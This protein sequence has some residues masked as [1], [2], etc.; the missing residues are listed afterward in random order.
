MFKGYVTKYFFRGLLTGINVSNKA[1]VSMNMKKYVTCVFIV[2][3][4]FAKISFAQSK[5]TY[6][7]KIEACD[8]RFRVDSNFLK[9]APKKLQTIFSNPLNKI[10]SSFETKCGY[11]IVPENR[12]KKNSNLVKLPFIVVKSKNPDKKKDPILYTAG[13]PG[14]SSVGWA[15]GITRSEL[16]K[17]RDCIAL[18]QRGTLYALPSLRTFEL[19]KAIKESYRKNL[20]KDSMVIV[21]LKQYKKKLEEKG[22]DLSGYNTDET[23]SDIHDLLSV[24]KIDSVNLYGGSYSGGLMTAVLQKDPS[25]IRS[26]VLDSPLPTFVPIDEDESAN[27]N[28]A[29]NILFR[30]V[31]Q[32][33]TDKAKY[34]N[35]KNRF[36]QYFTSIIGKKFYLPYLEVGTTDSIK[37]EYTKNELIDIIYDSLSD[38]AQ[39]KHAARL[40]TEI[41][42]GHHTPYMKKKFDDLFRKDQA[43]DGMRISV[44][45]A[46]ETGYHSE[47]VRQ[48]LNDAYPYMAR[49]HANDVYKEMCDCWKVPPI[50]LSTK[51]PLYSNKPVLLADGEMDSHCRPLYMDMIHHY[52]PNSQRLLFMGGTHM[53]LFGREGARLVKQFLD[54]PYKKVEPTNKNVIVY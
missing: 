22:I 14:V 37:I 47:A 29:L 25:R 10:D 9:I 6:T 5:Q 50:K 54:D 33:S 40:I 45:C 8:C 24:L 38:P 53:V 39:L 16:I 20:P 27:F 43:P 36:Q 44:C 12:N 41:I 18:E 1:I 17:N 23:V 48:R 51:L 2:I 4:A 11:L 15:V 35:L 28:E 7:P 42:D 34:G 30:H 26:L 31:E 19:D 21:G 3:V 52:M 46:D 13:G 32:D 49:Y